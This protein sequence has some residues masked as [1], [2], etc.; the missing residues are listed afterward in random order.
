LTAA[1]LGLLG[2]SCHYMNLAVIDQE[3]KIAL[4]GLAGLT[5]PAS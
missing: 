5:D 2:E 1:R 4:A 3:Q